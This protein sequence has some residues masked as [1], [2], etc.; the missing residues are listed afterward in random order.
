[1][2]DLDAN[3]LQETVDAHLYVNQILDESINP[4]PCNDLNADT[5]ITVFDAALINACS[6]YGTNYNIPNVGTFNY[7]NFPYGILNINDTV[8]FA[9][10]GINTID[11]YVDITIKNSNNEVLA[12]EMILKGLTI[13]SAVNMVDA[14]DYPAIPEYL[15]GG[16]KIICLSYIDSAINKTTV[17]KPLLRVYY[18]TIQ[19]TVC[20]EKIV[21][22]VNKDHQQTVHIISEPCK[23][24][25][26]VGSDQ[27]ESLYAGLKLSPNP[28]SDNVSL[29]LSLPAKQ[30]CTIKITDVTGRVVWSTER[31]VSYQI[32]ENID[33]S[34]LPAG[35]YSV[36]V[37]GNKN[38]LNRKLVI[39]K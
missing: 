29:E 7:C 37:D 18:E 20:I 3:H 32:T 11:K 17:H 34:F 27:Y 4:T 14:T 21:D 30:Y 35:T 12:Y 28:A 26:I 25:T 36:H 13:A 8:D 10:A 33:I 1:M 39:T 6:I 16:N 2:G 23:K 22:V 24:V 15:V 38:V 19:D 5:L 9:I 31:F